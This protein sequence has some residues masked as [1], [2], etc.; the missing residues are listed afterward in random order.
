MMIVE[1]TMNL[2]SIAL[3]VAANMLYMM[4]RDKNIQREHQQQ[5]QKQQQDSSFSALKPIWIQHQFCGMF[6]LR[7]WKLL[8]G[9]A[10]MAFFFSTVG[11]SLMELLSY[12]VGGSSHS[13]RWMI[14]VAIPYLEAFVALPSVALA[15]I[16][17]VALATIHLWNPRSLSSSS[18]QTHHLDNYHLQQHKKK[19]QALFERS[20]QLLIVFGVYW[21]IVDK[22]W[23][24]GH[25][26]VMTLKHFFFYRTLA[27]I[28][29]CVLALLL[30]LLMKQIQRSTRRHHHYFPLVPPTSSSIT[31]TNLADTA[32]SAE[33]KAR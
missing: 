32:N 10:Q 2:L 15:T 6:T 28:G 3:I 33:K 18:T 26:N 4:I 30:W 20:L 21:L 23:T 8:H 13:V 1:M 25:Q 11:G 5:Q 16:S 31:K 19:P 9:V 17:G 29:S 7:T 27:N 24:Q 22:L 12:T 14:P